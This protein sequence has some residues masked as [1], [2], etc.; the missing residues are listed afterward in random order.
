MVTKSGLH[1]NKQFP[2]SGLKAKYCV[3]VKA[4]RPYT[5]ARSKRAHVSSGVDKAARNFDKIVTTFLMPLVS[6]TLCYH[7]DTVRRS[8][9]DISP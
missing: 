8:F 4:G 1:Q 5:F 3:I 2:N 9:N 6:L 7:L